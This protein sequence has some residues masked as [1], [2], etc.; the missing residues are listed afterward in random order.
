MVFAHVRSSEAGCEPTCAEWISAEGR[1]VG[2]S[3]AKLKTAIEKI[4]KRKLPI[5][6]YSP[7]GDVTAAIAMGRLIRQRGLDIAVGADKLR[8]SD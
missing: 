7:G 4:G 3:A 6:I 1:I 2:D 5:V 8:S